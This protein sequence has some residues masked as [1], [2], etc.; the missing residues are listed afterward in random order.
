M[1]KTFISSKL[2]F[3]NT[4]PVVWYHRC[5]SSYLPSQVPRTL[6][7]LAHSFLGAKSVELHLWTYRCENI[8]VLQVFY[9]FIWLRMSKVLFFKS[10]LLFKRN[11]RDNIRVQKLKPFLI[12]AMLS[13]NGKWLRKFGCRMTK[14]EIILKMNSSN[15]T[16]TVASSFMVHKLNRRSHN[17]WSLWGVKANLIL[18][19]KK[20]LQRSIKTQVL[21][22]V[23]CLRFVLCCARPIE[24][25]LFFSCIRHLKQPS[26]HL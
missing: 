16:Q 4:G 18:F 2:K 8:L 21:T 13:R 23:R 26:L 12:K 19:S 24:L 25:E 5:S 7:Q 1:F 17:L 6:F 3:L 9:S 14:D 10:V 20:F 15:K 22:I 11:I